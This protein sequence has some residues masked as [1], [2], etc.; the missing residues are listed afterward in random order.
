MYTPD[1]KKALLELQGGDYK[2]RYETTIKEVEGGFVITHGVT[3]A[4]GDEIVGQTREQFVCSQPYDVTTA[5]AGLYGD[6]KDDMVPVIDPGPEQAGWNNQD[7][8]ADYV[9]LAEKA[10]LT[11]TGEIYSGKRTYPQTNQEPPTAEGKQRIL[12]AVQEQ[13]YQ[14]ILHQHD[15]PAQTKPQGEY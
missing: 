15:N 9:S 7:G 2:A 1:E 3:Y 12:D 11:P 14:G 6:R 4:N 10:P 8:A 13:S 5:I